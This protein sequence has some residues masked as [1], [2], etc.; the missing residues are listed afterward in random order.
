MTER[1]EVIGAA[2]VGLYLGWV[3][4]GGLRSGAV[5]YRTR[6]HRKEDEPKSYWL[7]IGWFGILALLALAWAA[8]RA[9]VVF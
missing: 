8:T 3:V 1:I 9:P 2:L 5:R 4:L 7:V 6:T